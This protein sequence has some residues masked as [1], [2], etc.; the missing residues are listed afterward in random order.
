MIIFC[1][2]DQKERDQIHKTHTH[3]LLLLCA[4]ML[5]FIF[6]VLKLRRR[7]LLYLSLTVIV[8]STSFEWIRSREFNSVA[9]RCRKSW[10]LMKMN[11]FQF[12][13]VDTIMGV[14]QRR[15]WKSDKV[16]FDFGSLEIKFE[17]PEFLCFHF[18]FEYFLKSSFPSTVFFTSFEIWPKSG[19]N[20]TLPLAC[21]DSL[22]FFAYPFFCLSQTPLESHNIWTIP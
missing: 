15:S 13:T 8:I 11:F 20:K 18:F 5:C 19:F 4:S 17:N 7:D 9:F 1:W 16:R 10:K 21:L 2:F 14:K 12:F 6:W 22:N 3:L